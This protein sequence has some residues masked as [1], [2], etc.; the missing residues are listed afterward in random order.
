M[1]GL[2]NE[3]HYTCRA[4]AENKLGLS[5]ASPPSN[6]FMACSGPLQCIPWLPWLLRFFLALLLVLLGLWLVNNWMNRKRR[7]VSAQ[8]DGFTAIE[9]GMGPEVGLMFSRDR[10]GRIVEIP[11][12]A[13]GS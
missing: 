7:Y 3:Q 10:R 6:D 1:T 12:N 9:L 5:P 4:H 8:V 11:G 13:N 2:V